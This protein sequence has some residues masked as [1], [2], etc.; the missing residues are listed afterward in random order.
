MHKSQTQFAV[1]EFAPWNQQLISATARTFWGIF[2]RYC[3]KI[4]FLNDTAPYGSS[5]NQLCSVPTNG[6]EGD[7]TQRAQR[8]TGIMN[9]TRNKKRSR[10]FHNHNILHWHASTCLCAPLQ[11]TVTQ[12]WIHFI[13]SFLHSFIHSSAIVPVSFDSHPPL[14]SPRCAEWIMAQMW[15]VVLFPGG[16]VECSLPGSLVLFFP[17]RSSSFLC[18]PIYLLRCSVYSAATI[19]CSIMS[20]LFCNSKIPEV[21]MLPHRKYLSLQSTV[22]KAVLWMHF[23]SVCE[24]CVSK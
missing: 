24:D 23:P 15:D 10:A 13:H 9:E 21:K 20:D 4:R 19:K 8:G 11:P 12:N 2:M 3:C 14:R 17:P 16:A 7:G 6:E 5:R 1:A 22:I 18:F